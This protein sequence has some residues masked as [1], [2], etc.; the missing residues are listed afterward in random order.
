[1]PCRCVTISPVS[2]DHHDHAK[3]ESHNSEGSDIRVVSKVESLDCIVATTKIGRELDHSTEPK[4]E[5][6]HVEMAEPNRLQ[7]Y[8]IPTKGFTSP[9]LD[10]GD[11]TN[12]AWIETSAAATANH[13]A[14]FGGLP[15][16]PPP[17]L[18]QPSLVPNYSMNTIEVNEKFTNEQGP[19]N[20][21]HVAERLYIDEHCQN[22]TSSRL[23]DRKRKRPK[24]NHYIENDFISPDQR[25]FLEA[26]DLLRTRHAAK[27]NPSIGE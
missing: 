9:L 15:L 7:Q 5:E 13:H 17:R 22:D 27:N 12:P 23:S 24:T 16:H 20:R 25:L 4:K 11:R 1:M 21:S 19:G 8:P 18:A 26:A 2:L 10:F 3:K 14:A 6:C